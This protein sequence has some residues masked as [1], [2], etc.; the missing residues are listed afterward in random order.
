MLSVSKQRV[1][2]LIGDH[3]DFPT[4]LARLAAGPVW[5]TDAIRVFEEN[6]PWKAAHHKRLLS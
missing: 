4:P 3:S 5:D 6:S 2:Q 1:T